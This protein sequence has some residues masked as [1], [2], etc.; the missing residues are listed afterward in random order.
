MGVA[1]DVR[2]P[3][4]VQAALQQVADAFGP[5]DVLVL[6]A[7]GNFPAP[8]VGIS[9]RGFKAV[10]DIDL[11]GTFHAA[12]FAFE[13]LRKPGAAVVAISAPQAVQPMPMQSH[14]CAAKAG[15]EMLVRCLALEWGAAGVRV[16]AISPGPIAGTEGMERLAPGDEARA[17][18][19]AAMPLQRLGTVDDVADAALFLVSDAARFVTGTVLAC[20]GG[21]ALLGGGL[22][23]QLA[24]G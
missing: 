13:H 1:A 4:A 17:R 24:A 8:A 5:I 20:D 2:E 15:V 18:I 23:F 3:E 22:V 14:V 7:A 16:N 19:A 6:G 9:S 21:Q 12:R 10:V 11:V